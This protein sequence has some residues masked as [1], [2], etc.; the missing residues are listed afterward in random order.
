[1]LEETKSRI[2]ESFQIKLLG[3]LRSFIGWKVHRKPSGIYLQQHSYISNL[4]SSLNLNHTKPQPTPMAS[5]DDFSS[6]SKK[7]EPLSTEDHSTYRSLIGAILYASVCTSPDISFATGALERK[8]HSPSKRHL[9]LAKRLVSY[10]AGTSSHSILY[11][12]RN[13]SS[14]PLSGHSDSD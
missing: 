1:M 11:P 3:S 9:V 14:D 7:D 12:K 6:S 10:L 8:V 4:V 13:G 5:S 2:S